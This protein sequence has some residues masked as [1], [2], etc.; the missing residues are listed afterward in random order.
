MGDQKPSSE[1]RRFPRLKQSCKIRY[2]RVASDSFPSEGSEAISV[3]ISGGGICFEVA[4]A[5]EPG[6]LLAIEL[7]LEEFD[8]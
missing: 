8:S 4:D 7:S 6:T 1:K 5:L 3:N 2:K